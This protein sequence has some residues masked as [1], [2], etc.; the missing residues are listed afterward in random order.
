MKKIFVPILFV[1][2]LAAV[3]GIAFAQTEGRRVTVAEAI[4]LADGSLVIVTG[5]IVEDLGNRKYILQDSTGRI[6]IHVGFFDGSIN[7]QMKTLRSTDRVEIFGDV[8]DEGRRSPIHVHVK[9]V[10]PL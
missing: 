4:A 7:R 3:A 6:E 10:T 9:R 1:F 2:I 8:H 5:F